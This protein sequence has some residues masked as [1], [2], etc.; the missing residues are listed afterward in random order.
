MLRRTP[1]LDSEVCAECGS[2][3]P[4]PEDGQ[5]PT[6]EDCGATRYD[7]DTL[8]L[9]AEVLSEQRNCKRVLGYVPGYAEAC[10]KGL[11]K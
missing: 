4:V 2:I 9:I 3:L 10:E 11:A 6:C 1:K 7:E 8:V 5:F